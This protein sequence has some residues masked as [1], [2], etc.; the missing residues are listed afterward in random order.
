MK[1]KSEKFSI[2]IRRDSSA[3]KLYRDKPNAAPA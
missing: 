3:V 2:T 1:T